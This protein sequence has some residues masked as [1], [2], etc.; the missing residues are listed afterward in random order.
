M[1]V[2][3][4]TRTRK[5]ALRLL[6]AMGDEKPAL[7]RADTWAGKAIRQC[8]VSDAFRTAFLRFLDVFPVLVSP[9]AL[10][11]HVQE[12]FGRPELAAQAEA[13]GIVRAEPDS[14]AALDT[15]SVL[16][17]RLAQMAGIFIAGAT[18][19]EAEPAFTALRGQGV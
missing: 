12:Y 4:E 11:R 6:K 1:A 19:H 7:F 16:S 18:F 14:T 10:S 9:E 13:L 17:V 5:T 2:S 3:L 8:L 15:A